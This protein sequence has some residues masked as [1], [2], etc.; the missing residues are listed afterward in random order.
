[1]SDTY[2]RKTVRGGV[3]AAVLDTNI[4]ASVLTFDIDV[5]TNWPDGSDGPFVVKINRT[6]ATE[7]SILCQSRTGTTITVKADGRGYDNTS[8][9]AHN[10]GEVV[11]HVL[12]G[13]L[14]DQVNRLANLLDAVGELYGF[15]G[16]NVVAVSAGTVD[17]QVL[18]RD[19]ASAAG[20][21]FDRLPVFTIASSAPS[22]TGIRR[23]WYDETL[24]ALRLSDG[25]EWLFDAGALIFADEGT[26]D[27][28]IPSPLVGLVV[29]VGSGASLTLSVHDGNEY[30]ELARG[31]NGI[32]RFANAAA[33]DVYWPSPATGYHAFLVDS[34]ALTEY[35]NDEWILL[36]QKITLSATQPTTNRQVGDIWIQPD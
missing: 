10:I 26:R 3:P 6:G 7:E 4:N 18:L 2:I 16:T 27:A 15:N 36:N 25:A 22:V 8:A 14:V 31:D 33:R 20:F 12:D 21:K 11:E 9:Y 17:E 1:M 30:I 29:G 35:R 24:N 5:A 19:A 13:H 28:T 32:L 34:H 23:L